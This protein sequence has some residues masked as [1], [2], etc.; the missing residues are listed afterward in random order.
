M[1]SVW[2][3]VIGAVSAI[4][5]AILANVV[6]SYIQKRRGED[7][8]KASAADM[9]SGAAARMVERWEARV[10]ELEH[11]VEELEGR[12]RHLEEEN[13]LLYD[14][15]Q[16]LEGQVRSLGQVPVWKVPQLYIDTA[17]GGP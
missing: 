10:I 17:K 12:V 1:D 5:V 9:L 16:R 8:D 14:G 11:R 15:A 13:H 7:G 3:A 4:I 2:I 6:P